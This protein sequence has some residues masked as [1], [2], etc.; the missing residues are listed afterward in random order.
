MKLAQRREK[1]LSAVVERYTASGEP[2]GSSAIAD[3][4]GVSSATVRNELK[5]LDVDGYLE[6]PHTSAGR[7]P[8]KQGYRYYIDYLMPHRQ[9]S[10][11]VS[12]HIEHI[13]R[14]G[15]ASPEYILRK[16]ASV[17]SELTDMAAVATSPSSADARVH[18]IRFVST[19]RHSSMAVLVTS[20]GMV[21]S[22]LFRCEFVLTPELLEMFDKAINDRFSGIRLTEITRGF[23]Q[24][25]ASS[26]GELSLFI[27][28]VLMALYEAVQNALQV[29]VAV[30]GETNLLFSD[31]YDIR[32]ARNVMRVLAD[33]NGIVELLNH[34]R[35]DAVYLGEESRIG[36]LAD[37]AVITSRY[38]IAGENAGAVAVIAPL[39]IDYCTVMGEVSFAASCVSRTIGELLEH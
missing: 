27:P 10:E 30:S 18:R 9:P 6:Q 12:S 8:T 21:Q 39:R 31:G 19:G 32:Y 33:S 17:L 34:S 23:L 14:S 26:M 29:S 5:A 24:T 2:V 15:R 25:T 1:I 7:V 16:T 4:I 35:G 38:E 20:N 36:G 28:D 37:S 13:I 22:R 3:S 11:R